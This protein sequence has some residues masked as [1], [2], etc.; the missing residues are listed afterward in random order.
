MRTFLISL[1]SIAFVFGLSVAGNWFHKQPMNVIEFTKWE[2][3]DATITAYS[4]RIEETDDDPYISA[5]G[6]RVFEG[7]IACPR[8]I[9]LYS[10][11]RVFGKEYSCLDRMHPRF[12]KR[13]DIFF[14]NTK[15]ALE[16]GKRSAEV[17]V[18]R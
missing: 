14:F 10:K 7:M 4:P 3:M 12:T 5:S 16:F 17:L 6:H 18:L 8:S 11:V 15:E 2:K 13:F 9:P 1:A